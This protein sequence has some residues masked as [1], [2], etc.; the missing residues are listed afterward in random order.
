MDESK[1]A[2][3]KNEIDKLNIEIVRLAFRIKK[4]EMWKAKANE[5]TIEIRTIGPNGK[6]N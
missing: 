1:I 4:L 3:L 5:E 6:R 2:D